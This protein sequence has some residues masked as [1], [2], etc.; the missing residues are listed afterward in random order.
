MAMR[1]GKGDAL[2]QQPGVQFLVVPEARD[3]Q[4]SCVRGRLIVIR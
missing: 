4:E 1:L 3:C 2:I